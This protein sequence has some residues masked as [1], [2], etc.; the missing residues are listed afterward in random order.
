MSCKGTDLVN[1]A[2][3]LLLTPQNAVLFAVTLPKRAPINLPQYVKY[4]ICPN[5]SNMQNMSN[6]SNMQNMEQNM[7]NMS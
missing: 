7:Q 3:K 5:M 6:M 4:A 1:H 2:L